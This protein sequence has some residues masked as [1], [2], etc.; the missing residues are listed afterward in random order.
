MRPIEELEALGVRSRVITSVTE[1]TAG[2]MKTK[3]G[4]GVDAD[5]M[6]WAAGVR[7]PTSCAIW[8][9]CRSRAAFSSSSARPPDDA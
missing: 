2:A 7:G 9:G 8:M 1:V 3:S 5:I 6:V 4:D